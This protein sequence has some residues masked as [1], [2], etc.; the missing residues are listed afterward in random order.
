MANHFYVIMNGRVEYFVIKFVS[1]YSVESL[2]KVYCCKNCSESRLCNVKA[3]E[4]C[5]SHVREENF[6][7][8]FGSEA[9]L[10]GGE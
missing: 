5:L 1:R 7:G 6:S 10:S 4:N 3:F 8:V 9:V 2:A